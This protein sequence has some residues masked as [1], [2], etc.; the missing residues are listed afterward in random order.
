MSGSN[1]FPHLVCEWVE[2]AVMRVYGWQAVLLQLLLYNLYKAL[3]A[4]IIVSPITDDLKH[5]QIVSNSSLQS[6]LLSYF[7]KR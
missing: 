1:H 7:M 2:H 5:K 3:H 4:L 6:T